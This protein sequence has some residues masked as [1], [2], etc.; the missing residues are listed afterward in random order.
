MIRAAAPGSVSSVSALW[1]AKPDDLVGHEV[2]AD[3]ALGDARLER[4]VDDA[5]TSVE[6]G[7]STAREARSSWISS[8]VVSRTSAP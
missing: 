7:R 8:T 3:H 1:R 4:L 6:R 2:A 5:A